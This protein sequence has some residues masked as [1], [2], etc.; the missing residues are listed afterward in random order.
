M[1]T[2]RDRAERLAVDSCLRIKGADG[3]YAAGDVA[4]GVTDGEH[5]SVMSCQHAIP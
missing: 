2:E 5:V 4:Q 1:G 3:V